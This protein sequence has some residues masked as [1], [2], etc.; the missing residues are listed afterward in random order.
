[1]LGPESTYEEK[2]RVPPPPPGAYP[3]PQGRY[4]AYKCETGFV[5]ISN[6]GISVHIECWGMVSSRFPT[7]DETT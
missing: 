2:M 3:F 4:F 7:L 6:T 5:Q 1:M